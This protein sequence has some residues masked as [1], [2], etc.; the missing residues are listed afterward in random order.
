METLDEL[1][2]EIFAL[3]G[4]IAATITDDEIEARL[5]RCF[6]GDARLGR[7]LAGSKARRAANYPSPHWSPGP[8]SD[9]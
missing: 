4:A 7:A 6:A 9:R 8:D 1:F 2:C 3:A 5:R